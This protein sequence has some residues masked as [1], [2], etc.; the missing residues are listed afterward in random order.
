MAKLK[1][2]HPYEFLGVVR[3]D[4]MCVYAEDDSGTRYNIVHLSE[5]IREDGTSEYIERGESAACLCVYPLS[6][7]LE[8]MFKVSKNKTVNPQP[9]KECT[10][11]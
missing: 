3:D 2:I 1:T 4:I 5:S 7:P 6:I 10:N 8:K 11:E 9:L